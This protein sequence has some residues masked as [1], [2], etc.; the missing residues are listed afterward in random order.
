MLRG[1]DVQ[2]QPQGGAMSE[3][4]P[5]K[6]TGDLRLDERKIDIPRRATASRPAPERSTSRGG[7][8]T[9]FQSSQSLAMGPVSAAIG[10][11]ILRDNPAYVPISG[12]ENA[13]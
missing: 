12:R 9:I 2:V 7:V 1:F 5:R 3:R 10:P 6:T 11:S 8:S 13:V 4:V